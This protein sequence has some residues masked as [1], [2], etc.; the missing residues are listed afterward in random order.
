VTRGLNVAIDEG[1]R[2]EALAFGTTVASG[3]ALAGATAFVA[4]RATPS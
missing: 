4:R 3:D 1:L 2:I